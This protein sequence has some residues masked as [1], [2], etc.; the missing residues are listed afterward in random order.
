MKKLLLTLLAMPTVV[1]LFLPLPSHANTAD[2]KIPTKQQPG[3]LCLFEHGKMYCVRQARPDASKLKQVRAITSN[4]EQGLTF[5]DADSEAAV[6]K[7]GCDCPNCIRAIKG[8]RAFTA[9]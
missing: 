9:S 5:T 6:A 1:G 8:M 4:Y 7:F 3:Q 2:T